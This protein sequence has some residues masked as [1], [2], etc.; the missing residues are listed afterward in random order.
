[1]A[2]KVDSKA[3]HGGAR[4]PTKS[5]LYARVSKYSTEMIE[6]LVDLARNAQQESVRMA[7]A[8]KL[9]D[10]CLADLKTSE[11]EVSGNVRVHIVEDKHNNNNE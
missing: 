3:K 11:V 4:I 10:K 9:L 5:S 8:G 1:M 2:K 7:A 6:V